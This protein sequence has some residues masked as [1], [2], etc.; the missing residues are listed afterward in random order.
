MQLE[1]SIEIRDTGEV[2]VQ[3]LPLKNRIVLGRGP[4][5]QVAL[6]GPLIFR[7]HIAFAIEQLSAR[8]AR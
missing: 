3:R 8:S 6:D 1:L 2:S 7:E 4:E 5:S